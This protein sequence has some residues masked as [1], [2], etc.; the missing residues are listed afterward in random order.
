M[1]KKRVLLL[2][3]TTLLAGCDK[4]PSAPSLA[5]TYRPPTF[6]PQDSVFTDRDLRAAIFSSYTGPPGFYT[7]DHST[8]SPAYLNSWSIHSPYVREFLLRYE[9]STDD[10]GEARLWADSSIAYSH[11]AGPLS[12]DGPLVTER[13]IEFLAPLGTRGYSLGLRAHRASYLDRS[14]AGR[15]TDPF[16]GTLRVRPVTPAAARSVAEYLWFLTYYPSGKTKPLTS[17]SRTSNGSVV[18]MVY[19]ATWLH[20]SVTGREEILLLRSEYW[21]DSVTGDIT[22]R[23][24]FVRYISPKL[25]I[26]GLLGGRALLDKGHI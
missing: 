8:S 9:L 18:H 25:D 21:I 4:L 24:D 14:R 22:L 19:S 3:L 11:G 10:P 23:R 17:F 5:P 13:Y 1:I 7:E 20:D 12:S 2:F 26:S 16:L 6:G 15:L